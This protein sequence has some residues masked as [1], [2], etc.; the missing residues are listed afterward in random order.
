MSG[1]VRHSRSLSPFS[2]MIVVRE[3]LAA[4]IRLG[5]AAPLDHHAP[6]A[7][8]DQDAL[9]R[10]G[11]QGGDAVGAGH[12]P[13]SVAARA[14]PGRGRWRRPG[15]RGSGC[16]S[17][18]R[19]SPP[20][21]AARTSRPPPTRRSG[22]ACR[23]RRRGPR[24][25]WRASTGTAMRQVEAMRFRPAKLVTGMMPGTMGMVTPAARTFVAEAQEAVEVEEELAERARGAG[26]DLGLQHIDIVV[27]RRALRMT[28]AD[29]RPRRSRTARCASD[30]AVSSVALA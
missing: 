18:S 2:G 22:G 27:D 10:G 14:R 30:A 17:G 9:A 11:L 26:V 3:P 15:R 1:R 25:G 5:E 7:V 29:R 23:D 16:R 20:P 6:R 19:R 4:E 21:P 28:S 12:A 8:E 24:T 13:A